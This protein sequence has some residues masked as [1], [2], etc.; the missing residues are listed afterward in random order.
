MLCR[1]V[2]NYAT[3]GLKNMQYVEQLLIMQCCVELVLIMQCYV[4]LVLIMITAQATAAF[5]SIM[6]SS[7]GALRWKS[8]VGE[9]R[10]SFSSS[11]SV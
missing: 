11:N 3:K 6:A 4:E 8:L 10:S 9:R 5:S 2:V 1:A 7:K